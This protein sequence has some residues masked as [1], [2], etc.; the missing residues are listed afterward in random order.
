MTE[1]KTSI[2]GAVADEIARH[3]SVIE[4]DSGAC[5][6]RLPVFY[7]NGSCVAVRIQKIPPLTETDSYLVSD[8][9]LAYD[10]AEAMGVATSFVRQAGEVA[11]RLGLAFIKHAFSVTNVPR[12]NLAWAALSVANAS[13]EAV[14][15][16]AQK[17]DEA[18]KENDSDLLYAKLVRVFSAKNVSRDVDIVGASNTHWPF[19]AM[20]N[21]SYVRTVFEAVANHRNSIYAASTK[22]RDVKASEGAPERV[23]MV[24]DK[25]SLGTMHNI[26]SMDCR[27][28]DWDADTELLQ[29]VVIH[30]G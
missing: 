24:R 20:V 3:V 8:Y 25:A 22:F 21:S 26:L 27:V 28:I 9:A 1:A 15:L 19:D 18:R 30:E 7:P 2:C 11:Q 17:V 13:C 16:A 5:F 23:A 10:E 6:I 12:A 14:V 4:T 29:R